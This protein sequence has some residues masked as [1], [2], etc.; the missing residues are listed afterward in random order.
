MSNTKLVF[1][2]SPMDG[3]M[4]HS[5]NAFTTADFGPI[6]TAIWHITFFRMFAMVAVW[7]NT[8][9]IN[10]RIL[11]LF[12]KTFALPHGFHGYPAYAAPIH[13]RIIPSQLRT[14]RI[15]RRNPPDVTTSRLFVLTDSLFTG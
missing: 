14:L 4:A 15:R 12:C 13:A 9:A 6:T 5:E 7:I 1:S 10:I 11:R 3:P 2:R 8:R